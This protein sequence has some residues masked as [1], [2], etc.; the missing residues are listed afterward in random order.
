MTTAIDLGRIQRRLAAYE[1]FQRGASI[2]EASRAHSVETYEVEDAIRMQWESGVQDLADAIADKL[3][4]TS[5]A[6][7]EK[8]VDWLKRTML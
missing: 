8:I 4:K 1:A 2:A 3:G 6:E 7:I 5:P